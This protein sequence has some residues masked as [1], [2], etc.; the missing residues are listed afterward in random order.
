MYATNI[1]PAVLYKFIPNLP[2]QVSITPKAITVPG[3]E[4]GKTPKNS[5]INFPLTFIFTIT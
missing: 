1:I 4:K 5:I 3:K 2:L